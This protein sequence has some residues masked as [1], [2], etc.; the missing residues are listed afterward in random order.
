MRKHLTLNMNNTL[1]NPAR[2]GGFIIEY[3]TPERRLTRNYH[4]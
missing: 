2:L 4:R 1:E 3:S